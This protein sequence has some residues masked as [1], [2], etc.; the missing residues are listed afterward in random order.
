M[1]KELAAIH[2]ALHQ[3]LGNS[4]NQWAHSLCLSSEPK[5]DIEHW[6]LIHALVIAR[7]VLAPLISSEETNNKEVINH[8]EEIHYG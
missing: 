7:N 1:N 3:L 2:T 4:L 8:Q 5:D 6:R